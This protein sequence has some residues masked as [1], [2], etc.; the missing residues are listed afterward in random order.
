MRRLVLFHVMD[1]LFSLN[2]SLSTER[3]ELALE[4][5]AYAELRICEV[6]KIR[7][8]SPKT[9]SVRALR[10]HRKLLQSR[11]SHLNINL[12]LLTRWLGWIMRRDS[13]G[14]V[15]TRECVQIR[16]AFSVGD[17]PTG[18]RVSSPVTWITWEEETNLV[19][20]IDKA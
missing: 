15:L 3:A 19:K 12:V 11:S 4:N 10:N 13:L 6:R 20:L 2:R 16:L 1:I 18:V 5:L 7:A 9:A 14:R 8:L 17:S